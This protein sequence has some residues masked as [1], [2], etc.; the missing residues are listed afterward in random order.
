MEEN[1][2]LVEEELLAVSFT[3]LCT[4][5]RVESG[6]QWILSECLLHKEET[7]LW[8]LQVSSGP[9]PGQITQSV[10]FLIHGTRGLGQIGKDKSCRAR[11]IGDAVFPII[12]Q[13]WNLEQ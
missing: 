10:S 9:V 1:V 5:S 11:Q 12:Y 4:T 8:R 3:A 13:P 6:T 2:S 7:H